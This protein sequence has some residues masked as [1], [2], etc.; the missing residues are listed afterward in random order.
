MVAGHRAV[1]AHNVERDV[2]T[3][4]RC[5]EEHP[6][7]AFSRDRA[8]SDGRGSYCKPC[9]RAH[10]AEWRAR[11]PEHVR[12]Y[13]RQQYRKLT[14]EQRERRRTQTREWLRDKYQNDPEWRAAWLAR[15][16][17]D[18]ARN[19]EPKK[20]AAKAWGQ[21]HPDAMIE[22]THRR[23]ARLRGVTIGPVSRKAVME[24]D[25]WICWICGEP[26][27][28]DGPRARRPSLDHVIALIDGGSH[29]EDNLRCAHVGCNSSRYNRRPKRK[30]PA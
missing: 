3:C 15:C 12:A 19:P 29:T 20:A 30:V 4:R 14:P 9:R 16:A 8:K 13:S 10:H 1:T 25:G 28:P 11:N 24:R 18:Y 21:A 2:K 5:G 27:E 22:V 7:D 17:A 6:L 23:R 26:T